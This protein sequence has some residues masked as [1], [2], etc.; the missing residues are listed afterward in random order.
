MKKTRRLMSIIC[1][2]LIVFMLLPIKVMAVDPSVVNAHIPQNVTITQL[3]VEENS[4]GDRFLVV[5]ASWDFDENISLYELYPFVSDSSGGLYL[6]P[7]ENGQ[8]VGNEASGAPEEVRFTSENGRS[9]YTFKL[10]ILKDDEEQFRQDENGK[11]AVG[12]RPG[13]VC[14]FMM[15]ALVGTEQGAYET[16]YSDPV[17]FTYND[18]PAIPDPEPVPPTQTP[19][20]VTTPNPQPSTP[21]KQL[22]TWIAV[23]VGVAGLALVG[24]GALIGVGL[25][26][27]KKKKKEDCV[28][29][30]IVCQATNPANQSKMPSPHT[31]EVKK[32]DKP[33]L[34]P[35]PHIEEFSQEEQNYTFPNTLTDQTCIF[36]YT[37]YNAT[38]V[39]ECK[40]ADPK[41]QD[42]MPAP[43][44]Y[45]VPRRPEPYPVPAPL[46]ER[47][48]GDPA[49]WTFPGTVRDQTY[50]FVYFAEFS[51]LTSEFKAM[52]P[53]LQDRM[54]AP[55]IKEVDRT[56]KPY[57]VFAPPV[58]K[59]YC[60]EGAWVFPDT[61]T[62]QEHAFYYDS[63]L[64]VLTINYKAL[65]PKHQDKMP[66]PDEIVV[67]K[68]AEPYSVLSK[69]VERFSC[70]TASYTFPDTLT[71]QEFTFYYDADFITLT[72]I[73]KALE[74]Q[75]QD[76][77]PSDR[78]MEVDKSME[79]IYIDSTPVE[80]FKPQHDQYLM[81]NT[82]MDDSYTIY[83]ERNFVI[84]TL[85]CKAF[86]PALQNRMPA[87]QK[88]EVDIQYGPYYVEAPVVNNFHCPEKSWT[89]P[90]T[91]NDRFH[92]FDYVADFITLT[93]HY[94]AKDSSYQHL[95]PADYV[96]EIDSN[97][98]YSIQSPNVSGFV[99][100]EN[101][102]IGGASGADIEKTV[103]Y[104]KLAYTLNVFY[105]SSDKAEQRK[106]PSTY[107]QEIQVG[108]K[109]SVE[110]PK[111]DG[112][113]ASIALVSGTMEEKD[114]SY[115]VK[116][117]KIVDHS[118]SFDVKGGL[119]EIS[120]QKVAHNH[121]ATRPTDPVK[122]G[123]TFDN[124]YIDE[125]LTVPFDF[126]TPITSNILLIAKWK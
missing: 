11:F 16:D 13:Q 34:V 3:K 19:D 62:D 78:I 27:G 52:N 24:G 72:I 77:M 124:W 93:I 28:T 17:E 36:H 121:L 88:L 73:H 30:T 40:A 44:V 49:V 90:D 58:D 50:T 15:T 96:Q 83:Y 14:V 66:K 125:T 6:M 23:G 4:A 86:K 55:E 112:Y 80:R 56:N 33:Y 108:Q 10:R 99:P 12:L 106:M 104:K 79:N 113:V 20:P 126:N 114:V 64:V 21:N 60:H 109:Y 25:V 105:E 87:P 120:A 95:M 18:G 41:Y 32:S 22:I 46:V 43:L 110:S 70:V 111:V 31:I 107:Q 29:L 115:T 118:V 59:F 51:T 26:V 81:I 122:E 89:F 103:T 37:L 98:S 117:N 85:E 8:S 1:V 67:D 94:R 61:L 75:Y 76:K 74:A 45:R 68:K 7:S 116:Y 69:F 119:P 123:F 102:I 101:I 91:R 92:T 47:F 9:K 100:D 57:T 35:A 2:A 38:L 65:D 97:G 82:G 71:D 48:H 84:L 42:R 39:L 63:E 53:K 5:E 54:P